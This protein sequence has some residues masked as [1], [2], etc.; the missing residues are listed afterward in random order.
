MIT[1]TDITDLIENLGYEI[2]QT[3]EPFNTEFN[4]LIIR[5][6]KDSKPVFT[7]KAYYSIDL[8]LKDV[9]SAI[10]LDYKNLLRNIVKRGLLTMS[11][12]L[13]TKEIITN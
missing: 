9:Q 5:I 13:G 6:F 2:K 10:W 8:Q 11:S 7:L 4:E 1:V 12:E 3:Y